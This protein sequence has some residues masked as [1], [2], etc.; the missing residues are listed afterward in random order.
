MAA[1]DSGN[2]IDVLI[3][4][5]RELSIRRIKTLLVHA[6]LPLPDASEPECSIVNG[7]NQ[8]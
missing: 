3:V 4:H 6:G 7:V 5:G 8:G 2:G 1:V